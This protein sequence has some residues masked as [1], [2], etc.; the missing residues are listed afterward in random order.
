MSIETYL[1]SIETSRNTIRTKLVELGMVGSAAKLDACAAVIADLINQGAVS[2]EI[3]EGKTYTIPAG[4]HNGAGVVKAVSDAAG[5]AE[6]Y[7]TQAKTATPTKNQQTITP[8]DG[9]YALESV[10]IT[11]IPDN[12]QDVSGVTAGADDVLAGKIIVLADGTVKAG[13]MPNIGEVNRILNVSSPTYTIPRGYHDGNGKATIN[14]EEKT[15]TPTKSA[16]AITPTSGKVL[17]KVAVEK[18]PDQYQDVSGVTTKAANVLDGDIFVD[19][20]GAE[21]EGTMPNNGAVDASFD[22]LSVDSYTIP[23]GYHDGTGTVRLND[24]IEEALAAI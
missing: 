15:V 1:E 23:K 13:T 20:T 22:G 3:K 9:Y 5:D 16:Q 24:A 18:I 12:Y 21:V 7:K 4:Y 8:D 11:A 2:V 19:A 10:V 17:S 6:A 14:L